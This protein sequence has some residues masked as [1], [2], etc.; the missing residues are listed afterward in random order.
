MNRHL[1]LFEFFN[2]NE[3][4][5]YE[6]NLSR[7]F[8]I[9]LKHDTVFLK[10]ILQIVLSEGQHNRIFN[11]ELPNFQIDIDLQ[12]RA[13]DL[14]SCN[15][16]IA[17]A[18]SGQEIDLST[19]NSVIPRSEV[20]AITD[21]SI[22]IDGI[23]IIFEFKRTSEDCTAQL[24]GQVLEIKEQ[25]DI[26]VNYI[27][28]NWSKIVKELLQVQAIQNLIHTPNPFTENFLK[29]L[30]RKHPEW[31][32]TKPLINI[33]YPEDK[34]GDN[35]NKLHLSNRL[36]Q[37]KEHIALELDAETEDI[38]SRKSIKVNW[39][40]ANE[41]NIQPEVLD[42]QQYITIRFH[43]G[44]TKAQGWHLYKKGKQGI[45]WENKINDIDLDIKPYFKFSHF[46]SG[47]LWHFVDF[48]S[49]HYKSAF[50][51]DFFSEFA[52]RYKKK[53]WEKFNKNLTERI[54]DWH[55]NQGFKKE[56]LDTKRTYFDFSMGIRLRAKIPYKT[57]MSLDSNLQSKEL[58]I[59]L[60]DTVIAIKNV[61]DNQSDTKL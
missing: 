33:P 31:F 18:C 32:P 20:D 13:Q 52:G 12:K 38:G 60:K 8:A 16:I 41:V 35:P 15:E 49:N 17:V 1:N 6:D 42:N 25:N 47:I 36:N 21:V 34:E 48:N 61:I 7:A 14:R 28:L 40:W 39:K 54:D 59:K 43:T 44:D 5:L 45:K 30:N 9:C 23:C 27:D 50:N 53:D 56:F 46:N 24:M 4:H 57:C 29:F 58:S 26:D 22:T 19:L 55:T 11:T 37:I 3:A 10:S 51:Y 2:N